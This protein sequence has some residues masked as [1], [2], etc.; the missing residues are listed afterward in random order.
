MYRAQGVSPAHGQNHGY[1]VVIPTYLATGRALFAA[2]GIISLGKTRPQFLG[3]RPAIPADAH[4]PRW[5][6]RIVEV[7][8]ADLV[9]RFF[10]KA[11]CYN[12]AQ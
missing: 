11:R 3:I 12:S 8:E 10:P 1:G 5:P 2:R 6:W 4:P 9:P 7:P